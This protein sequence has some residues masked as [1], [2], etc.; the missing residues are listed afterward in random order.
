MDAWETQDIDNSTQ[1]VGDRK[2][3]T[4]RSEKHE[5]RK[6]AGR[7]KF[8]KS[9]PVV[10]ED[11]SII[12]LECMKMFGDFWICPMFNKNEMLLGFARK[13]KSKK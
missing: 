1:E 10:T 11:T 4:S 8:L 7:N 3:G 2:S 9:K 12:W 6:D 13:Y 5:D